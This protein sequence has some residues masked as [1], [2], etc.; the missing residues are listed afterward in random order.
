MFRD[1]LK[2]RVFFDSE[3]TQKQ[4]LEPTQ[5]ENICDPSYPDVCMSP[6]PLDLNCGEIQYFYHK[7]FC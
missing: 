1:E 3:S 7:F 5:L 2:S 4:V 6:Y